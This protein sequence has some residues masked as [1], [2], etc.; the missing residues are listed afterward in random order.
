MNVSS[1]MHWAP[2]LAA[3][4]FIAFLVIFSFDALDD[5]VGV[6]FLIHNVPALI[7]AIL[8]ALAWRY[9]VIGAV[10]YSAVA[11]WYAVTVLRLVAAERLTATVAVQWYAVI[12]VPALVIA[13]L[14]TVDCR[15]RPGRKG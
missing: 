9:P 6:A 10:T 1:I 14:F 7:L 11:L 3:I 12:G 15:R 2:R 13:A 5:G 4:A 8:L